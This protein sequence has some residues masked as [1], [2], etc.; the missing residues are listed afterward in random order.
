LRPGRACKS[1]P[2]FGAAA[3][4]I[5]WRC[6]RITRAGG[7][8]A[9]GMRK[10]GAPPWFARIPMRKAPSCPLSPPT[11]TGYIGTNPARVFRPLAR[12]ISCSTWRC[13]S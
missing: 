11:A 6:T 4:S 7:A 9:A 1:Q 2:R 10:T 8:S 3:G 13:M 12:P 5:G